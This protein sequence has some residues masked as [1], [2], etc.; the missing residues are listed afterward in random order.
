MKPFATNQ[1]LARVRLP[2]DAG[3][4][5]QRGRDHFAAPL[6]NARIAAQRAE[7]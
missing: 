3:V 6:A 2:V 1:R 5:Q 4:L 7:K